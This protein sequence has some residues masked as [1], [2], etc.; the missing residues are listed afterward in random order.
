MIDRGSAVSAVRLL[1][2]DASRHSL[3]A[4]AAMT[5]AA[6]GSALDQP[7]VPL[8]SSPASRSQDRWVQNTV[9]LGS[10]TAEREP[11]SRPARR[12]A[13]DRNVMTAGLT[14]AKALW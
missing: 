5:R 12:W 8:G 7:S 6:I 2:F 10:A 11:S 13:Q 14:A 4:T 9:R 1:P 3:R